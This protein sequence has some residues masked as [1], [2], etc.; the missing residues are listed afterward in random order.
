MIVTQGNALFNNGGV[1]WNISVVGTGDWAGLY[2]YGGRLVD[3][4]A[5]Y[6]GVEYVLPSVIPAPGSW[7]P[8]GS[9]NITK[10]ANYVIV[11]NMSSYDPVRRGDTI[12]IGKETLM[13]ADFSDTG[14]SYIAGTQLGSYGSVTTL[15]YTVLP[16]S[17]PY[18]G[19]SLTHVTVYKVLNCT[20]GKYAVTYTPKIRGT[21][22]IH[23]QTLSVNEIQQ[24]QF[25]TSGSGTLTGN[26]TLSITTTDVTTGR[27]VQGTTRVLPLGATPATATQITAALNALTN[28]GGV[29]VTL[30]PV[31]GCTATTCIYTITFL[32]MNA[33]LPLVTVDAT[34]VEGNELWVEVAEVQA[35]Q[36]A[37]E[38]AQSPFS[39]TVM[40]NTTS[41]VYS[42]AYGP[43]LTQGITGATSVFA[44]Q[45]PFPL[46]HDLLLITHG[47]DPCTHTTILTLN[48]RFSQ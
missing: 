3:D 45:V 13:V 16:L 22:L 4:I 42:E 39:L 10:G 35:G 30:D 38:I 23:V 44:I 5:Y 15:G 34:F 26:Y 41:A 29:S 47:L 19:A 11:V 25:Y 32:H 17:R 40:P 9:G 33:N 24:V 18:L 36:A 8:L 48:P 27:S 2:G 31:Y 1:S 7:V 21:Y 37:A 46:L 6:G 20:T 43:G 12:L 28:L 14:R